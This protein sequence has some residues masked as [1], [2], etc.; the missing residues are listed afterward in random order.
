MTLSVQTL[1][2]LAELRQHTD[3]RFLERDTVEVVSASLDEPVTLAQLNAHAVALGL[4][5]ATVSVTRTQR[6]DPCGEGSIR[7]CAL[8]SYR[9][10]TDEEYT[11]KINQQWA[12][13]ERSR[14]AAQGIDVDALALYQKLHAQFGQ[15]AT[16]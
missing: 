1:E 13:R 2:R 7:S 11:T 5:P 10:Q 12:R 3:A 15:A 9:L 16:Q 6:P 14:L 8:M 4:D